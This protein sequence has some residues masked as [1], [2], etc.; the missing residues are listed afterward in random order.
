[1]SNLIYHVAKRPS[2]K[3]WE[4]YSSHAASNEPGAV[5]VKFTPC[6]MR[7]EYVTRKQA[8]G[9]ARLLAGWRGAV[10]EHK[11][12]LEPFTRGEV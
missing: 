12:K 3:G 6:T 1:M 10:I 9:I 2:G 11:G 4:V 8:Q 5:V 7:G